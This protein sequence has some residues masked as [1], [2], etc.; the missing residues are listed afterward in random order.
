MFKDISKR[1]ISLFMA[2]LTLYSVCMFSTVDAA[3]TTESGGIV[4]YVSDGGP[5]YSGRYERD[6]DFY[7]GK[8]GLFGKKGKINFVNFCSGLTGAEEKFY[9]EY[10]RFDVCIVKNGI[11]KKCYFLKAG[12]TFKIP[13]GKNMKVWVH[14]RIDSSGWEQFRK[15]MKKGM[16]WSF[17]QYNL[18][19]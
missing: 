16:A 14:S 15:H 6:T 4:V 12:D 5:Y 19:Y 3:A 8:V 17:A 11:V 13:S 7:I 2:V 1:A 18:T 10:A 9:K